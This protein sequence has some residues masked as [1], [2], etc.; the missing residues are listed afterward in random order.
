MLHYLR[1]IRQKLIIQENAKKYLL[2][3]IGE[4]LL[5]VI[6][7]LIALQINNWNEDR[8]KR[9]QELKV[10][11]QIQAD[12]SINLN[13]VNDLATKLEFSKNSSDSLLKS[14][15]STEKIRAFTFHASLIHRR[16]F[17]NISSSGYSL[18]SGSLGTLISNDLLRNGIVELYENDFIEIEK[19]QQML[20]NHLDQNLN[21]KS[22]QLFEIRQQIEFTI[23]EF[24]ENSLDLY[25]PIDYQ[26]ISTNLEYINTIIILKRMY[27][28]QLKQLYDTRINLES[29]LALL[30]SDINILKN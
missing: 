25:E 3:A 30:E 26:K 8:I 23:K 22:N 4:I 6:G 29:M 19:R 24:D 2:Y 13:E 5:V 27:D 14:F 12:L 10:L 16:F 28:I 17:F 15:R 7:I 9:T 21:P 1:Q 18:L 11:T 20:S